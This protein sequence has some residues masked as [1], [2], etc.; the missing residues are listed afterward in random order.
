MQQ[1]ERERR[2]KETACT[3][4]AHKGRRNRNGASERSGSTTETAG[5]VATLGPTPT[6]NAVGAADNAPVRVGNSSTPASSDTGAANAA[7]TELQTN[8]PGGGT[9]SQ[10]VPHLKKD[11]RT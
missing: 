3:G 9:K 11:H 4:V 10:D 7:G 6:P 5:V 1:V 8:P 2:I